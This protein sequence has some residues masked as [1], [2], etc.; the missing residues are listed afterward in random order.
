MKTKITYILLLLMTTVS[1]SWLFAQDPQFS[2]FYA[3][4]LGVN[5]ALAGNGDASWRLVGIHRSQWIASGVDPLYTTSVSLD[6]KLFRQKDNEVNYIGGGLFFLQDR[7]MGGAYKTLPLMPF[8][9][10]M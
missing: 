2:Q 8:L 6:G 1:G 4:P 10:R 7:G 3:S 9:A 5:P